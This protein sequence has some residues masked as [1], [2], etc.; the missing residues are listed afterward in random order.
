MPISLPPTPLARAP[1]FPFW[2]QIGRESVRP[3][4]PKETCEESNTSEYPTF[5]EMVEMGLIQMDSEPFTGTSQAKQS[6]KMGPGAIPTTN[7]SVG[8]GGGKV[9]HCA[10]WWASLINPFVHL[11]S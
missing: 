4:H 8:L 3:Q 2:A 7:H 1:P 10:H 5:S 11:N 6:M 9:A